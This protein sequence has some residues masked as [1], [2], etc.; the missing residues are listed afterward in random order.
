MIID[1]I[2]ITV[3]PSYLGTDTTHR[4]LRLKVQTSGKPATLLSEVYR[5]S[6][7]ESHFDYLMGRASRALKEALGLLLEG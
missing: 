5:L 2:Q 7:L 4:Q 1:S 6:D 3:E